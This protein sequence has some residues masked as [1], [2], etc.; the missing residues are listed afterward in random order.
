[1]GILGIP[2]NIISIMALPLIVGIGID[3]GVHVY[4]RIRK[5][6]A[7]GPALLHSGKAVTLTSLTTGIGFGS[8]LLSVH[9]GFYALGFVT[10]TGVIC[11]LV[12]SILLLPALV[13]IFDPESIPNEPRTGT[14]ATVAPPPGSGSLGPHG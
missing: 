6:G 9:R 8:L 13:A 2:F 14:F 7:L 10:L 3:D 4:H 5:E 11:C 12:I 1:L